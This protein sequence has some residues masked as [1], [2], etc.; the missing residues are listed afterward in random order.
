MVPGDWEFEDVGDVGTGAASSW[1]DMGL[2]PDGP[3]EAELGTKQKARAE[4]CDTALQFHQ[5]QTQRPD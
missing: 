5:Y 3:E 2:Q 4:K 1:G